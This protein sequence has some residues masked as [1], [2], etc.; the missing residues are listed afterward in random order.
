MDILEED[1]EYQI[2]SYSLVVNDNFIIFESQFFLLHPTSCHVEFLI[3]V[4]I[5]ISLLSGFRNCL[6]YKARKHVPQVVH[7]S[8]LN[9]D[10]LL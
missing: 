10:V 7:N 4:W 2:W 1:C 8:K 6:Q 3:N 5:L 9:S